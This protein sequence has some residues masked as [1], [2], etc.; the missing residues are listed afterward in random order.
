M[1]DVKIGEVVLA[2][3]VVRPVYQAANGRQYILGDDG[4]SLWCL[5]AGGERLQLLLFVSGFRS[6]PFPLCHQI[7]QK[8]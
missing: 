1:A 7:A 8:E 5:D 2:D 6:E 4:E 3:K